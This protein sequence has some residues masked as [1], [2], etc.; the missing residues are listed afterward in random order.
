L[1]LALL[2]S[3]RAGAAETGEEAE[4]GQ[5]APEVAGWRRG[6]LA[7]AHAGI[8][9]F[10]EKQSDGAGVGFR[11]GMLVG[12]RLGEHVSLGGELIVD[13]LN[14]RRLLPDRPLSAYAAELAFSPLYHLALS[15][16]VLLVGGPRLGVFGSLGRE[17]VAQVSN[18]TWGEGVAA[19]LQLGGFYGVGDQ[20]ALGGLVSLGFRKYLRVCSE[21]YGA[22][23]RCF[24]EGLGDGVVNIGLTAAALF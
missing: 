20:A 14:L 16:A 21:P 8:Q 2:A 12:R 15:P 23:G 13:V 18:D 10:P 3:W 9:S 17:H 24:T 19:G 1:V 5:G 6:T 7:V 4:E 11:A 22:S